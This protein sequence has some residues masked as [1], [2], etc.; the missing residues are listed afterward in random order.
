MDSARVR[1]EHKA[2]EITE[3]LLTDFIREITGFLNAR[4]KPVSPKSDL[5]S[6]PKAEQEP[7]KATEEI[8][9]PTPIPVAEET[10]P[11][12]TQPEEVKVA[13]EPEPEKP[14]PAGLTPI[15]DLPPLKPLSGAG[16]L[17][18]LKKVPRGMQSRQP[19]PTKSRLE[20]AIDFMKLLI[21]NCDINQVN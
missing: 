7:V 13:T 1:R 9:Q 18:A 4:R 3:S 21:N 14:K 6:P 15:S 2:E 12:P 10:T 19:V 17:P 5:G 8:V 20:K 11:P 16:G